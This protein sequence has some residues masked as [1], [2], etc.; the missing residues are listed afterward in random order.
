M[1]AS[2]YTYESALKIKF[3]YV[4]YYILSTEIWEL[5]RSKS[6]KIKSQ[7]DIVQKGEAWTFVGIKVQGTVDRIYEIIVMVNRRLD[8]FSSRAW[9]T[10]A[11]GQLVKPGIPNSTWIGRDLPH[12]KH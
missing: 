9:L 1:I 11:G 6:G 3:H 12:L 10:C 8:R 4:I 2:C 5:G 7:L